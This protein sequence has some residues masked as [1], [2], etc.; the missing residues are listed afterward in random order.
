MK[1]TED[2]NVLEILTL[3]PDAEEIFKRHGLSCAGCPG[4]SIETLKEAA[5]GH[6]IELKRLLEDLNKD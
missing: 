5:E 3:N 1:I 4:S 2:M 6:D